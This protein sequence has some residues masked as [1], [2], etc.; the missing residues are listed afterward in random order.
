MIFSDMIKNQ[1]PEAKVGVMSRLEVELVPAYSQSIRAV[2]RNILH[3][4]KNT[5]CVTRAHI[6]IY[7]R[8]VESSCKSIGQHSAVRARK[9][10][11][12]DPPVVGFGKPLGAAAPEYCF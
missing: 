5:V 7:I 11:T 2:L 10:N 8:D 4:H 12:P 3:E 1:K 9:G 6:Y